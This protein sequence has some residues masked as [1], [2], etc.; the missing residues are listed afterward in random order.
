MCSVLLHANNI[1]Y[2]FCGITTSHTYS[3]ILV[4]GVSLRIWSRFLDIVQISGVNT[5]AVL[6]T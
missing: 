3:A 2:D 1:Q 6:H 4:L 5:P